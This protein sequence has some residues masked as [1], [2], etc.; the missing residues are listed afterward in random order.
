MSFFLAAEAGGPTITA[1]GW[2][3]EN[4]Y[5]IPLIMAISFATILFFGKRMPRGGSEVGIAAVGVCFLLALI[6]AGQWIGQVNRADSCTINPEDQHVICDGIDVTEAEKAAA[7][8]DPVSTFGDGE[9]AA[10][11]TGFTAFAAEEDGEKQHPGVKAAVSQRTWWSNGGIDFTVGTMVD[12]LTVTLLVVVTLI[13]SLVHIYS[14]DY[15]AGDRRY[16]HFFAF[17]SLFTAAMLFFVTSENTLQMIVGWELVG[18]CSFALIGHWWEDQDNSDA[19]LKAFLTNRVGDMGLLI[20]M[21]VLFFASGETWSIIGINEAAISGETSHT[22]LLIGSLCL[23]AA[24]MSKSGQFFLHTWLPDAMAGPTPVSALIHAATMVV[25]GIYLVARL[26]GVFFEGLSISGSSLNALALVGGLTTLVGASLAFV[27]DDIKKVLAYST[28]SQLGYMAMAL[29]VGA[30]TAAIFHL[31]THAFFK[32]LLF[33]G[34]GSVSHAVHS[35]DMKKDMGGM[36]KFMPT[37]YKTFLIGSIALAG[38]PPL[39]GFWSK[40]E[41]LVGTGGWGFFEGESHANG[42]YTVMLIMGMITAA[43]TAAYM[44]RV[45]YLTFFGEFR[46]GHHDDH[47]H[48]EDH[49]HDEAAEVDHAHAVAHHDDDSHDDHHGHHGEPHESG[50]RILWPL[51]ILAFLAVVVGFLNLPKGFLGLPKSILQ[52]FEHFVEPVGVSY[53]PGISHGDPS[54]SLAIVSTIVV[55]LAVG[56]AYRYYFVTVNRQSPAATEMV[57]GPTERFP[58][59]KAGHT[60]LKNRYYLDHIYDGGEPVGAAGATAVA[61]IFGAAA[62]LA[63]GFSLDNGLDQ[64]FVPSLIWGVV[65]G[66]TVF[67]IVSLA[68]RTGVGVASFVKGRLAWAANWS[69]EHLIDGTVDTIGETSVKSANFVYR[70]IDQGVIDGT[71]NAAGAGSSGAGDELRRWSTGQV[72]QYATVMFAGATLLAGLL[73]IVI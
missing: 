68:L 8:G 15:V 24:V 9:F 34:A 59:L 65:L 7:A 43:M 48:D 73:I 18:V 50:P 51:R 1:E 6:T 70:Y 11:A 47:V 54:W 49:A 19:A 62:G 31:F 37:T 26:Y 53:F 55:S 30:W 33:L 45:M 52:R 69:H 38:L 36:R 41:I 57:N 14:T 3:L 16:T 46:G 44:T 10:G 71:V 42:A 17:L 66:V 28:I 29:G 58:L 64:D 2:F 25:A 63:L 13:S 56:V 20:G 40:D 12:G 72:Q 23:I 67:T 61:T 39:A 27:Q 22:L 5:I 32:A 21:I 4:V 60:M 35:F